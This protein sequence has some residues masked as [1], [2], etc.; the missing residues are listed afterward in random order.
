MY[1]SAPIYRL[2][3]QAK[4]IARAQNL[5]LH[6]ALDLIAA[7][8]GFQSWAHL[9]ALAGANK[10][11][12]ALL[13]GFQ[14]GDLFLIGARPGQGKTKLALKLAVEAMR[15]GQGAVFFSLEWTENRLL[16]F[17]TKHGG[18]TPE[19]AKSVQIDVSDEISADYIAGRLDDVPAG[20]VAIVDYLQLLDRN[21]EKP[22]LQAQLQ[23]LKQ[24]SNS[25]NVRLAFLSQIDRRFE[26]SRKSVP[27]FS[28]IRLP[29]PID[30]SIF[31]HGCFLQSGE[32]S[33][34]RTCR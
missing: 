24:F 6:H 2:K 4:K 34:I 15:A 5:P 16:Q 22:G 1:P 7:Q 11:A 10:T 21:R 8:H 13:K 3:Q 19:Q 17:L 32:V 27:D 20:F 33:R 28:D 29:N 9:A 12:K 25:K 26:L 31:D 18:C 14:P 23:I 30:V